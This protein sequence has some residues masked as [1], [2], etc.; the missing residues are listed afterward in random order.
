MRRKI[1]L[2]LYTLAI[3]LTIV[4]GWTIYVYMPNAEVIA[5]G[6]AMLKSYNQNH[7]TYETKQIGGN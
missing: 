7:I 3:V 2:V 4:W 6:E 1:E 5:R